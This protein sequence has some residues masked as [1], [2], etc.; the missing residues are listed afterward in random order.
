MLGCDGGKHL[1][2]IDQQGCAEKES[3]ELL[4][5]AAQVGLR[6]LPEV[7]HLEI[8]VVLELVF[9][10]PHKFYRSPENARYVGI[11]AW[12]LVEALMMIVIY[13]ASLAL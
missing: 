8:F 12:S 3:A 6:R 2:L 4:M 13:C 9:L 11:L 1:G 5:E 7:F 10:P